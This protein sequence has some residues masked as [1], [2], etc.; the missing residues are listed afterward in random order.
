MEGTRGGHPIVIGLDS[1]GEMTAGG[2]GELL[3]QPQNIRELVAEGVLAEESGLDFFGLGEHHIEEMPLSAPDLVLAAVA[4]RT[5]RIRLGSA[6]TVLSSDDPVR[7]FQRYATLDALSS[8]RAE[9]ILGRGSSVESFPLFGFDLADYD[10]L[11]EE[12][13][14]LFARLR[15]EQPV[16][17]SGTTR[18]ALPG[19]QVYPHTARGALPT[20]VG[21]GGNPASVVRAA[22]YGFSLM[23]AI[24]GGNPARFTRL[25][26]LYREAAAGS[27]S[28]PPPIGVHSPGHVAATDE[29][30]KEEYWPTYRTFLLDVR[31]RRGFP[32]I[33]REYFEHEVEHGSLYVGS[34]ETVARRIATTM[35]TLGATRF[36]LKY[37]MGP[38]P[39]TTLME[40]IRLFGTEVAPRVRERL[41][42]P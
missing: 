8:G 17:W 4:A 15:A 24:I 29:Q 23:L 37:G 10:R 20:W 25:S 19:L 26:E 2:D 21:V 40:N 12:K 35:T 14:D 32:E 34:P 33:T 13:L 28:A 39:H 36:D 22:R 31:R 6:V 7:V 41:L 30:A 11:F 3:S 1:F 18:A 9:V 16:T 27:G 42:T 5:S 38:M